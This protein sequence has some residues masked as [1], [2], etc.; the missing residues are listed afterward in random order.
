MGNV[1]SDKNQTQPRLK[2]VKGTDGLEKVLSNRLNTLRSNGS[3]NHKIT[4]NNSIDE[5]KIMNKTLGKILNQTCFQLILNFSLITIIGN[6]IIPS[7]DL[8]KLHTSTDKHCDQ[9]SVEM[10]DNSMNKNSISMSERENDIKN[11]NTDSHIHID[12]VA[13]KMVIYAKSIIHTYF[14][15]SLKTAHKRSFSS[16]D[17]DT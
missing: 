6:E 8:T 16:E 7:L 1:E 14:I 5:N 12:Q 4:E 17:A 11:L 10:I 2:F 9:Y 15:D 3:N 13:S